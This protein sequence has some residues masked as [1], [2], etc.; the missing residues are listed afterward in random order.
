MGE[1]HLTVGMVAG[2]MSQVSDSERWGTRRISSIEC[3]IDGFIHGLTSCG[4]VL[5]G[6]G[7]NEFVAVI[8]FFKKERI[9]SILWSCMT[10]LLS[11]FDRCVG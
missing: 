7:R 3:R 9:S 5:N 8:E 4:G 6:F 11:I 2:G 10:Y 1:S